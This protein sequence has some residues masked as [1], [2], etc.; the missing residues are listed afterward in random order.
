MNQKYLND[1][2]IISAGIIAI[3]LGFMARKY[4]WHFSLKYVVPVIMIAA[5]VYLRISLHSGN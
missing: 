1:I 2:I 4:K 5:L 3:F